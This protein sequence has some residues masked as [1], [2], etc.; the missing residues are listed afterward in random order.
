MELWG[1]PPATRTGMFSGW[2]GIIDIPIGKKNKEPVLSLKQPL[3]DLQLELYLD[4]KLA[5]AFRSED[6]LAFV[7]SLNGSFPLLMFETQH[8][9]EVSC[10]SLEDDRKRETASTPENQGYSSISST[11]FEL[12]Y[13]GHRHTQVDFK[14]EK[15]FTNKMWHIG[16]LLW[17]IYL[18]GQ[19]FKK[20]KFVFFIWLNNQLW[21]YNIS[22]RS[23]IYTCNILS[24]LKNS[25]KK[26][27]CEL[28]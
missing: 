11:S 25:L 22:I 6:L 17:F 3:V 7:K 27:F 10:V 13:Q 9:R 23:W 20:R 15:L 19:N 26:L 24:L 18:P 1:P 4:S 14:R 21:G 12:G 28:S 5:K 2:K 16:N 8:S